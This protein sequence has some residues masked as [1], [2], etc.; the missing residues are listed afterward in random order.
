MKALYL[1]TLNALSTLVSS[2]IAGRV[3]A[4]A[5]A[6]S[7]LRER[8][9]AEA[10]IGSNSDDVSQVCLCNQS[11]AVRAKHVPISDS[12]RPQLGYTTQ[13]TRNGLVRP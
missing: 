10:G 1:S 12:G 3:D 11:T 4:G 5:L 13:P 9:S 6:Y 2:S 8:C 7:S